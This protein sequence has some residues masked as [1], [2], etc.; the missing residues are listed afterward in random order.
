MRELLRGVLLIGLWVFLTPTLIAT[1]YKIK[2]YSEFSMFEH[3]PPPFL[4]LF[5]DHDGLKAKNVRLYWQGGE[6]LCG[7]DSQIIESLPTN[8]S[9]TFGGKGQCS[10]SIESDANRENIAK[11]SCGTE[12]YVYRVMENCA[13]PL[14]YKAFSS[15]DA[16]LGMVFSTLVVLL[17]AWRLKRKN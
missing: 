5:R 8:G 12:R 2:P 4:I 3:E 1:I 16:L 10:F 15:S 7:R 13:T 11:L 6:K 9:Q 14:S 17:F